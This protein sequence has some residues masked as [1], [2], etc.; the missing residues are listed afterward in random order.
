LGHCWVCGL[1]TFCSDFIDYVEC[2]IDICDI[3]QVNKVIGIGTT[4]HKFVDVA[5]NNILLCVSYHLP[6]TDIWLFSPQ[7]YHQIYGGH[8]VVN[9]NEAVMRVREEGHPITNAI[10]IDRDGTNLPVVRNLVVSEKIK[11]EACIQVQVCFKC[12]WT[13]CSSSLLWQ[14]IIFRTI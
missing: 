13:L 8:S 7:V 12:N 6:L 1:D 11:K 5:G 10:P 14:L 4:L 2:D 9:G 3:T